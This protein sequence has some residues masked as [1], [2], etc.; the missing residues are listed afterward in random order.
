MANQSF[1]MS[2]NVNTWM[3]EREVLKVV[4]GRERGLPTHETITQW[5]EVGINGVRLKSIESSRSSH[6]HVYR[7]YTPA[8][9][10][11]F[12]NAVN[13]SY[14]VSDPVED[15]IKR[16][17]AAATVER[18]KAMENRGGNSSSNGGR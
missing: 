1:S 14:G 8:M 3:R 7:Y 2:P 5:R 10:F 15:E 12:F 17:A 18:I 9:F 4:F 11:E 13:R 16:K 6:G